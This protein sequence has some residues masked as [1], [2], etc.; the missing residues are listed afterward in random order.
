MSTSLTEPTE[1]L[2]HLQHALTI[3]GAETLRSFLAAYQPAD[4]ADVL[5]NLSNEEQ[6]RLFEEVEPEYGARIIRTLEYDDQRTLVRTFPKRL[7][8]RLLGAM[9]SDDLVDLL[10]TFPPEEVE[11]ILALIPDDAEAVRGLMQ[12]PETSAGGIMTHDFIAIPGDTSVDDT[13][14]HLR[15]LR[16]DS[17][18]AYYIYVTD[19]N[20]K[21][22]GV[23]SLRQLIIAQPHQRISEIVTSDVISVPA[24]MDQEDVIRLI[25][26]YAFLALPVVDEFGRPLGVITVD[27]VIDAIKEETSEDIAR[28]GG[29]EPLEEGYLSARVTRLVRK[30][31]GWLLVLFAAQSLT[32]NILSIYE[33]TIATVTVLAIFIPLLIGTGGNAGAQASTLVVRAMAVGEVGFGD[34]IR[35]ISRESFVGLILGGVMALIAFFWSQVF[36]TGLAIGLTVGITVLVIVVLASCVGAALPIVAQ[37]LGLDP[38]VASAPMV[39]TVADASGLF[40]YFLIARTILNL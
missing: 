35:V 7:Q 39:T 26:R 4:I 2:S 27:D 23:V 36:G 15:T 6:R 28:M 10:A 21:L 11:G 31:L 12:Y 13:L 40:V 33:E 16:P 30:R 3:K 8:A 18:T 38:A 20:G 9:S 5:L 1:I 24:D 29:F 19:A 25:E 14:I 22:T 34:I 32:G 37:R 17:E